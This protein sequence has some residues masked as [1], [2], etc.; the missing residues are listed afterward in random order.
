M[1]A[2]D[3]TQRQPGPAQGAMFFERLDRVMRTGGVETTGGGKERADQ[4]LISAYQ[5]DQR[6]GQQIFHCGLRSP[7]P[8]ASLLASVLASLSSK[9][10]ISVRQCD[11]SIAATGRSKR[12]TMSSAGKPGRL[13]RKASRA[14]RL[15]ALRRTAQR[16]C[17]L[18][19]TR[20]RRGCF[21]AFSLKCSANRSPRTTCR[22]WKT[23]ENSCGLSSRKQRPK[24]NRPGSATRPQRFKR[25]QTA[26]R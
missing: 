7:T 22:A 16:A 2:Q 8:S 3:A 15:I 23:A 24:P 19:S 9:L 4:Q 18:G 11:F 17:F 26:R 21:R 1:T 5:P 10:S 12:R 14:C 20:P 25:D 13:R 6:L